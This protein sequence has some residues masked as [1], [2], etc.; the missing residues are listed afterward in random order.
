MYNIISSVFPH[1]NETEEKFRRLNI[2]L[3]KKLII[4]RIAISYRQ[5]R[6]SGGGGGSRNPPEF[7]V[8]KSGVGGLN[9]PPP[10]FE[11]IFLKIVHIC[12]YV[13]VISIG[14]GRLATIN[15]PN[16]IYVFSST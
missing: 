15:S 4:Y 13:Q 14:G 12:Y 9:P 16:Y 10:D 1:N 7:A 5:G 6:Q 8:D 3:F 2:L 11:R